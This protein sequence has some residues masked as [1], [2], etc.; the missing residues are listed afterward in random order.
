MDL[1]HNQL[2]SV[3]LMLSP[4]VPADMVSGPEDDDGMIPW[5][6]IASK[7]TGEQVAELEKALGYALPALFV[8]LIT[9]KSTLSLEYDQL[10]FIPLPSDNGFF[11]LMQWMRDQ[12]LS[13]GLLEKGLIIF[14]FSRDDESYYC[15]RANNPLF[16]DQA[17]LDYPVVLFDP[18]DESCKDCGQVYDSF[19][20]LLDALVREVDKGGV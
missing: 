9:Y 5:K 14:A 12:S 13:L 6:P 20:G 11:N 19:S 18:T 7:I 10:R 1:T 15:F 4:V 8:D 16:K 17:G 3:G 2:A